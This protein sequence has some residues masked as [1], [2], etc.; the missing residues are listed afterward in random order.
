M[1]HQVRVSHELRHITWMVVLGLELITLD[2]QAETPA[3]P[4]P[5]LGESS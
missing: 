2:H 5:Q 1:H 4:P 3:T